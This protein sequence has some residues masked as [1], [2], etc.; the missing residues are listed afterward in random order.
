MDEK[1]T[2]G[3][4]N[5]I[6][7]GTVIAL[8][9]IGYLVLCFLADTAHMMPKTVVNGVDLSGMTREEAVNALND[10]TEKRCDEAVLTVLT[11][12]A[13]HTLNLGSIM[14]CN[15][16]MLVERAFARNQCGFFSRGLLLLGA[17]CIGYEEEALPD[18]PDMERLYEMME[19]EGVLNSGST[20]PTSY[21]EEEGQLV[22]TM[23]T[24]GYVVD[25]GKLATEIV[26]AVRE[27][28]YQ[29][30]IEC[31]MIPGIVEPVDLDKVY[32]EVFRKPVDASVDKKNDCQIIESV[33]GVSFDVESAKAA[34][35]AAEEG[36]R[37]AVDLIYTEPEITTVDMQE[38]LFAD[39]LASY[40]TGVSGS[41]NRLANIWLAV[42][43]CNNA[44]LLQ[45][46]Q[47]SFNDMVGDQTEET[48]F[49]MAGAIENGKPVQAYGGGICQ[50]S[51]TIF[52]AALYA[53]LEITERWNH[54]LVSGYIPAG[55]DAAVAYGELDFRFTNNTK[56]PMKL[57]IEYGNGYL[58]VTLLG[59][60]MSEARVMI[61]TE[62]LSS[63]ST[64]LEV[65][66]YRK[67]LDSEGSETLREQVAYSKYMR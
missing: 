6:L 36:S 26:T 47:F 11:E 52:A 3:K 66:T 5:R 35:D 37:V 50:L 53:N 2:G 24:A 61:E 27:R 34:L 55:M 12:D 14:E 15:C 48:G 31:P 62:V 64:A 32:Q 9:L 21:R 40:T 54:D 67:V 4:L 45:G 63:S 56:Y 38:H 8:L 20:I 58:T 65:E 46:E 60:R 23:G 44:V 17:L 10:D 22:F 16:E 7:P 49:K 41:A 59:S 43:K 51:S 42:E 18:V 28:D 39:E 19:A 29:T 1:R 33:T 13:A 30:V 57:E 25:K